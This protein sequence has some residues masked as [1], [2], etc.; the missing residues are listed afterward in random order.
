MVRIRAVKGIPKEYGK[1]AHE[2][3]AFV[4]EHEAAAADSMWYRMSSRNVLSEMANLQRKGH[5]LE[6]ITQVMQAVP[7][8][9]AAIEGKP[10]VAD[11][12]LGA[13][14]AKSEEVALTR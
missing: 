9:S 11:V 13:Y 14:Q 5:S 12:I 7:G 6:D 4:R 10:T 1:L 8:W 2:L 3:E